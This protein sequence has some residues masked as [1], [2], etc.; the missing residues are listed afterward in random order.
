MNNHSKIGVTIAECR[1]KPDNQNKAQK[2]REPKRPFYQY[3]EKD[4]NLPTK[5]IH[6]TNNSV[7]LLLKNY[8]NF[9]QQSPYRNNY[10]GRSPS[11]RNSQNRYSRSYTQIIKIEIISQDQTQTEVIN[12]TTI[13]IIP[14]QFLEIDNIQT[15]DQETFHIIETGFAQMKK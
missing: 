6:S 7:K 5:N 8:K 12:R 2:Y 13:E 3:M 14:I 11:R 10:R 9:R 1:K 15:I 4:Q